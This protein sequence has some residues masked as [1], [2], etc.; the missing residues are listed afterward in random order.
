MNKRKLIDGTEV[1]ELNNPIILTV[2]TKCP[3]KWILV[4]KETGETYTGYNTQ[5]KN[6]WKKIQSLK[7]IFLK[8]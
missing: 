1:I 8:K 2:K 3:E 5:G 7:D 4:D 6:S